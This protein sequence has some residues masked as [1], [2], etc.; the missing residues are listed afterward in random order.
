MVGGENRCV[1]RVEYFNEGQWG[2]ICGE[3]WD[4]NDAG[5]V[6]RQL[7]CGKAFKMTTMTEFGSATSQQI[8]DTFQCNGYESTISQCTMTKVQDRI[9]NATSIAGA[10]C[11]G[12]KKLHS[13]SINAH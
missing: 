5:V 9:C 2:T 7:N 8:V 10:M 1:G 6:C 13:H 11:K 12:K 3:S 4:F